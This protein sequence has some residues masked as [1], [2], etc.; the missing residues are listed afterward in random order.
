[1]KAKMV[2]LSD[3]S[4]DGILC[5]GHRLQPLNWQR[6]SKLDRRLLARCE[7]EDT[8]ATTSFKLE[9]ECNNHGSALKNRIDNVF[10]TAIVVKTSKLQIFER[11]QE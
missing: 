2:C 11:K 3:A 5:G 1:M 10:T 7:M 8:H 6:L 9:T 4:S